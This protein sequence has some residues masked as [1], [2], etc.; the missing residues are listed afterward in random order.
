M[1]EIRLQGY[2]AHKK[3]APPPRTA[4]GAK[5]WS[6]CRVILQGPTGWRGTPVPVTSRGRRTERTQSTPYP[7]YSRGNALKWARLTSLTLTS[8][9]VAADGG[10]VGWWVGWGGGGGVKFSSDVACVMACFD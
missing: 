7:E 10:G 8:E 3:T 6:F 9:G 4:T 2:L 5:P 1:R